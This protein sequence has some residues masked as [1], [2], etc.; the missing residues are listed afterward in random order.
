[1][2]KKKNAYSGDVPFYPD[3]TSFA[4]GLFVFL[5]VIK[6]EF[7]EVAYTPFSLYTSKLCT[8]PQRKIEKARA[9]LS[10]GLTKMY[11]RLIHQV[12]SGDLLVWDSHGGL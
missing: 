3:P 7:P 5:I 12:L 10:W 9:E 2:I 8:I 11:G 6:S 1:M 4:L